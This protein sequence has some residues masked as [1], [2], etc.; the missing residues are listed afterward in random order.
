MAVKVANNAIFVEV[1]KSLHF[2]H[3]LAMRIRPK[4]FSY[5]SAALW[6][7]V[8]LFLSN[9][10]IQLLVLSSKLPGYYPLLELFER[11]IANTKESAAL[12]LITIALVIGTIKARTALA[13]TAKR[14]VDRHRS[15]SEA[16]PIWMLYD[17]ATYFLIGAMMGIGILLRVSGTPTDIRAFILLTVGF[18]LMQGALRTLTY[19]R[20]AFR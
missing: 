1:D 16:M 12:V 14:S 20:E 8:G 9:T 19:G 4:T 5:L 6:L 10:G 3:N 11:T 13:K 7:A 15:F 17:K 2:L 18:A